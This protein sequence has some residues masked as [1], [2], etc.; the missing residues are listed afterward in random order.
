MTTQLPSWID[1]DRDTIRRDNALVI[2]SYH[3]SYADAQR[4]LARPGEKDNIDSAVYYLEHMVDEVLMYS[5]DALVSHSNRPTKPAK[6]Q[7]LEGFRWIGWVPH[8]LAHGMGWRMRP[9]FEIFARH[10]HPA[11]I[12]DFHTWAD[13]FLV[14]VQTMLDAHNALGRK[15]SRMTEAPVQL[16]EILLVEAMEALVRLVGMLCL[17]PKTAKRFVHFNKLVSQYKAKG[18]RLG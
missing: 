11:I 6:G 15:K 12:E 4:R 3:R 1:R 9:A 14:R 10:G 8:Y 17:D 5:F 2:D 13:A 18:Q 7:I 16:F